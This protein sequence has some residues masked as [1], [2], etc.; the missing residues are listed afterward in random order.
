MLGGINFW[1]RYWIRVAVAEPKAVNSSN[2]LCPEGLRKHPLTMR[3]SIY[4][5]EEIEGADPQQVDLFYVFFRH[6]Y[7]VFSEA[8]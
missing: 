1:L 8:L 2:M 6:M 3:H 5:I 4:E 7:P